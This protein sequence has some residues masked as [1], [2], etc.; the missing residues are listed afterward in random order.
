MV[1]RIRKPTRAH[2]YITEWRESRGLS[3]EQ[4]AGRLDVARETVW[5]WEIEQHRLN[6]E[7]IAGIADALN[8]EPAELYR[9]PGRPSLDAM[10]KGVPD[11]LYNTAADIVRRLAKRN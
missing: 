1:T 4:L 9:P 3:V 10:L 2:L 8:M 11:D 6:P 7:K 5:R